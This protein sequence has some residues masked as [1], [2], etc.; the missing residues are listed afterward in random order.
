M[1]K[2]TMRAPNDNP[3][4]PDNGI[5]TSDKEKNA[6]SAPTMG[7]ILIQR[8]NKNA[9]TTALV[10]SKP[11][12]SLSLFFIVEYPFLVKGDAEMC[13]TKVLMNKDIFNIKNKRGQHEI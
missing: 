4:T 8:H 9:I 2:T 6:K 7:L 13:H 12:R 10:R 3:T 5:I 1:R 11:I